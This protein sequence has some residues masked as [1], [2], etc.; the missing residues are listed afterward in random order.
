M[1]HTNHPAE[2]RKPS[3]PHILYPPGGLLIWG[4]VGMEL[5]TFSIA[6]VAL[7]VSSHSDPAAFHASRLLLNPTFGVINTIFL[8]VSGYFMAESVRFFQKSDLLKTRR[9]ILFAL[10]GGTCFLILKGIE[11]QGKLAHGLDIRYDTFFTYYWLLTVFHVIH[12]LA[13]MAILTFLYVRIKKS[14]PPLSQDDFEA[15]ATFWH[16]CD[17]IWLILF[18]ALYLIL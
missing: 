2:V 3:A 10:L 14:A 12:V 16:M 8:L 9:N 6:I 11:Y 1:S 4:L 17:L 18:P 7:M 5:F 13:G 15:G